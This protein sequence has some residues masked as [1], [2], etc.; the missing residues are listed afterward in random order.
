MEKQNRGDQ[1]I[2]PFDITPNYTSQHEHNGVDAPRIKANNII[3]LQP[4]GLPGTFTYYVSATSGGSPT[5]KLT[6]L[7]GILVKNT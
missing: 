4:I 7:N 3:G 5:V 6:F 2:Q 1:P